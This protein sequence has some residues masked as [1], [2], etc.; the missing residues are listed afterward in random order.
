MLLLRFFLLVIVVFALAGCQSTSL[1]R[2][3]SAAHSEDDVINAWNHACSMY[4]FDSISGCA[5]VLVGSLYHGA[6]FTNDVDGL[7]RSIQIEVDSACRPDVDEEDCLP[8]VIGDPVWY[9]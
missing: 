4:N 8:S 5:S 3:I 2:D 9:E 1:G 7:M 6:G